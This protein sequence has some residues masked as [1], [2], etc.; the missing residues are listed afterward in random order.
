MKKENLKERAMAHIQAMLMQGQLQWGDQVSEE[1]IA[2]TIGMSRTPVREALHHFTQLGIFQRIHRV[3]TVVRIPE[4]REI[5]ELFEIRTAMESYALSEGIGFLSVDELMQMDA[6]CDQLARL[7]SAL[8]EK[9][10]HNLSPDQ[11]LE[12]YEADLQFHSLLTGSTGNRL[13]VKHMT[14]NRTLTRIIGGPHLQQFGETNIAFIE[15]EHRA[16]LDAIRRSDKDAAAR[17]LV[18]HIRNSKAGVVL[19][20]KKN[21]NAIASTTGAPRLHWSARK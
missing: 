4:I 7:V 11:M 15:Q 5:E 9:G 14:D 18:A 6:S 19:F 10:Q 1:T 21:L 17:L 13:M 20:T 3:G 16:I 2:K 12:L 8:R